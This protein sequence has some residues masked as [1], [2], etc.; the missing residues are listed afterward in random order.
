MLCL[1]CLVKKKQPRILIVDDDPN[2]RK[3]CGLVL[4]YL[5]Q[6]DVAADASS[7]IGWL[8][9]ARNEPY[10]VVVLDLNLPDASGILVLDICEK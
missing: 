4:R 2:Q 10:H 5:G 6:I 1:Q 3:L 9:C 8:A 7:G